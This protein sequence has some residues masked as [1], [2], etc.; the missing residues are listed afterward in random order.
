MLRFRR[1]PKYDVKLRG[2][3]DI[4]VEVLLQELYEKVSFTQ[5]NIKHV[6]VSSTSCLSKTIF[7]KRMIRYEAS[8][9][10]QVITKYGHL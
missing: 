9:S 2:V 1:G 4:T 3:D 5:I 8:F 6:I 7:V 10:R